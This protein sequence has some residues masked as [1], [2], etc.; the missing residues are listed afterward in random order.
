MKMLL[1]LFPQRSLFICCAGVDHLCNRIAKGV[2]S[3]R[4]PASS[5]S[6]TAA[7][8]WLP[9]AANGVTVAFQFGEAI[10]LLEKAR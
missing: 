1:Y 8:N 9:I 5:L 7:L 3:I 4:P 6:A 10:N 2:I